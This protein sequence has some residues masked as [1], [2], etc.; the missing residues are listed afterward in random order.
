MMSNCQGNTSLEYNGVSYAVHWCGKC[1]I[2][3]ALKVCS[4]SFDL[5][6]ASS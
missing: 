3:I 1:E 5:H 2:T 4:V 6:T